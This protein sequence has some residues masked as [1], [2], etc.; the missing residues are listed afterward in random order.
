MGTKKL[1]RTSITIGKQARFQM[2]QEAQGETQVLRAVA[3]GSPW[4]RVLQRAVIA[5]LRLLIPII[6]AF[7]KLAQKIVR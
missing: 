4:K 5:I 7:L 3:S 2:S 6:N 1:S